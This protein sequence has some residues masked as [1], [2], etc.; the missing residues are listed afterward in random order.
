M[1]NKL[2]ALFKNKSVEIKSETQEERMTRIAREIA[3]LSEVYVILSTSQADMQNGL[4]IPYVGIHE[5]SKIL[6]FFNSYEKAKNYLDKNGYEVLEG[7]HAIGKLTKDAPLH[8]FQNVLNIAWGLGVDWFDF[9]PLEPDANGFNISWFLQETKLL[10]ELTV[11]TSGEQLKKQMENGAISASVP[12]HFN[13]IPIVNFKNPFAISEEREKQLQQGIFAD[14]GDLNETVIHYYEQRSLCENCYLVEFLN[15]F[16]MPKARE[17]QK[18]DDLEY[19]E[20]IR[21]IVQIAIEMDLPSQKLFLLKEKAT[22]ELLIR[23]KKLYVLYTDL[24]KYMG[25]YDYQPTTLAEVAEIIRKK[26]IENIC[27]TNGPGPVA[28]IPAKGIEKDY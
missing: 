27:V 18:E 22:Q 14:Y 10:T 5:G 25:H 7:I 6:F 13:P 20:Y 28:L 9:N 4:S 26:Q 21:S 23:D 15:M 2:K 24:F 8:S 17:M 12:L 1:F 19:F 16:M 3:D 11:L